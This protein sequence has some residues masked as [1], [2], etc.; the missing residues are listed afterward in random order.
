MYLNIE[1][2]STLRKSLGKNCKKSLNLTISN[3]WRPT[4]GH[5]H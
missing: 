1:N 5:N 2:T 4:S 3:D